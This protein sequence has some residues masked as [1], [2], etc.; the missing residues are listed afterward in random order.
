MH[1]VLFGA[2]LVLQGI[3]CLYSKSNGVVKN[4]WKECISM[5]RQCMPSFAVVIALNL[6]STN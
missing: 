6:K 2:A 3:S 1:V 5:T 4:Q